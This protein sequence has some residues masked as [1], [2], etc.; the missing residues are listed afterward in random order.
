MPFHGDV[1]DFG[2][3]VIGAGPAGTTATELDGVLG[4]SV[5]LVEQDIDD[6]A[7]VSG[8]G[9]LGKPFREAAVHLSSSGK[10]DLRDCPFRAAGGDVR[11]SGSGTVKSVSSSGRPLWSGSVSAACI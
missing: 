3:V 10:E 7:E 6:G 11:P 5:A 4:Y 2:P 9:G 8:G 1:R